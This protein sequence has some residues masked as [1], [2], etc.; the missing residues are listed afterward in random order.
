MTSTKENA[1]R[2]QGVATYANTPKFYP[3]RRAKAVIAWLAVW[4]LIP[5]GFA[6]WL[7]QRGGMRHA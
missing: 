4:G 3:K 5:A 6:S 7:L 2:E 1:L